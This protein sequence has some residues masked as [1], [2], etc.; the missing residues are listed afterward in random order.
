MNLKKFK[1]LDEARVALLK[2]VTKWIEDNKNVYYENSGILRLQVSL[3]QAHPLE[4]LTL[5]DCNSKIYWE[6]ESVN[7]VRNKIIKNLDKNVLVK[8]AFYNVAND[9][10]KF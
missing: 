4:W 7:K 5:Q 8:E 10:L 9:G 1:T 2:Q 6:N 3:E